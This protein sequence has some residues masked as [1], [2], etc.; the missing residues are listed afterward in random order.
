MLKIKNVQIIIVSLAIFVVLCALIFAPEYPKKV[1]RFSKSLFQ[2][3]VPTYSQNSLNQIISAKEAENKRALLDAFLPHLNKNM[4]DLRLMKLPDQVVEIAGQK[5]KISKFRANFLNL[6]KRVPERGPA[7]IDFKDNKLFIVQEN[8][9][10]FIVPKNDFLSDKDTLNASFYE[11]NITNF[12]NYFEFFSSGQFGIKDILII[13]NKIYVSYIHEM[14]PDCFNTSILESEISKKLIFSIF[15]SPR[16]CIK[17]EIPNFNAHQSGGRLSMYKNNQILFSTGEYRARLTAQKLDN[18]F[19]KILAINLDSGEAKNISIGHR[20]PQGLYYS[21]QYDEIFS[22]EHGPN[23]G[24][25][26]NHNTNPNSDDIE[27]FGWPIASYGGHYGGSEYELVNN[28]LKLKEYRDMK[29]YEY[30][31]L[32]KNHKKYGFTEPLM[33]FSPSSGISQIIEVEKNFLEFKNKRTLIFGTMGYAVTNFIPSLSIFVMSLD[34]KNI[35]RTEKQI[36]L[37]ERVRDLI[38]DHETDAVFFSG[39]SNGVIG[40]FYKTE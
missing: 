16:Q 33:H 4:L 7:Y 12:I 15:Y 22:T 2:K 14:E 32:H 18:P 3:Y 23:G 30:A 9:L 17:K 26:V 31:P 24:D 5:F 35:F 27:N 20:N 6:V 11:S 40:I 13:K 1:F 39:D 29:E 38:Y 28:A 21:Q 19:G 34:K 10:F 8:G 37:N 36:V 25:E